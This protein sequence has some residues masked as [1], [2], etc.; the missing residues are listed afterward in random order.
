MEPVRWRLEYSEEQQVG[1]GTLARTTAVMAKI[2]YVAY[3]SNSYIGAGMG[4][5]STAMD[6]F[7]VNQYDASRVGHTTITY[8]TFGTGASLYGEEG[9]LS[10]NMFVASQEEIEAVVGNDVM[11]FSDLVLDYLTENGSIPLYFTRDLG[12][13][14]NNFICLTATGDVVQRT[15][16]TH[17]GVQFM[18]QTWYGCVER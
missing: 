2:C 18:V 6:G 13:N 1:Y 3:I 15:A 12:T 16:K 7:I 10:A 17:I 9:S 8:Q 5:T 14:Y 11:E 4:V